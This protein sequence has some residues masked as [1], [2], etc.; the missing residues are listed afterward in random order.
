MALRS[1]T[2]SCVPATAGCEYRDAE[3]PL[4][5][6]GHAPQNFLRARALRCAHAGLLTV[7][8]AHA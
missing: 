2:K 3:Q 8:G 6:H 7:L 5:L 4:G 1:T